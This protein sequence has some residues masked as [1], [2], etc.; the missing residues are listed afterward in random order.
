[1]QYFR[2]AIMV[3]WTKVGT[4]A[5][6]HQWLNSGYILRVRMKGFF[7]SRGDMM[8]DRRGRVTDVT[9]IRSWDNGKNGIA[10]NRDVAGAGEAGLGRSSSLDTLC[11]DA[12]TSS[13]RSSREWTRA[14]GAEG[15]DGTRGDI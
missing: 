7:F 6:S 5:G 3:A 13:T 4:V 15:R 11:C 1:M 9:K 12:C 2:Q 10:I 8:S 14:S